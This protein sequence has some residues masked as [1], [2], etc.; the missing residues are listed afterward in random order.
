MELCNVMGLWDV[1][2]NE[3]NVLLTLCMPVGNMLVDFLLRKEAALGS[4]WH[5]HNEA[6]HG[7]MECK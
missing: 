1:D 7:L 2:F 4:Y 5:R 3:L 6:R